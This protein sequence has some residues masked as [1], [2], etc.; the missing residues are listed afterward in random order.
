[1]ADVV[2]FDY[3]QLTG[4]SKRFVDQS[5]QVRAQY[6]KV[7]QQMDVLKNGAWIGPNADKFYEIMESTLLPATK[8]LFS[9]LD[10]AGETTNQVAKMM[11]DAEEQ[12]KSLF[13]T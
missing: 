3:E 4:I 12:S 13:P 11:K 9:A 1:M 6:D 5:D 2:Q 8:K 10:K 7:L